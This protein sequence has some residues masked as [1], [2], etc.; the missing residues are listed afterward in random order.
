MTENFMTENRLTENFSALL[1]DG[2]FKSFG[3]QRRPALKNVTAR[4]EGGQITGLVGPDGA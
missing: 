3:P 4:I 1:I 2:V